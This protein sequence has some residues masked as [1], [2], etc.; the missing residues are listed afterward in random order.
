[1]GKLCKNLH[2]YVDLDPET[3][4]SYAYSNSDSS[5]ICHI[6]TLLV[7][8]V[9]QHYQDTEISNMGPGKLIALLQGAPHAPVPRPGLT[10]VWFCL[11]QSHYIICDTAPSS[12]PHL[13][14]DPHYSSTF[15][16]S[17]KNLHLHVVLPEIDKT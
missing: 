12:A 15:K 1:M 13:T 10:S 7:F 2:I 4:I 11:Q 16:F 5:V 14:P 9:S 6:K 3:F 17:R 8:R